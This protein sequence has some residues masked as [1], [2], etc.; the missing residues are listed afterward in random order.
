MLGSASLDLGVVKHVSFHMGGLCQ[1]KKALG[2]TWL[3][4]AVVTKVKHF[5]LVY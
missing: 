1:G 2:S 4:C 5:A 3:Q